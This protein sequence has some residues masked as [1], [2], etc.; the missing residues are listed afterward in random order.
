MV[1]A[2]EKSCAWQ[3]ESGLVAHGPGTSGI[4][5]GADIKKAK[6][7]MVEVSRAMDTDPEYG[8]LVLETPEVWGV[9]DLGA[10]SVVIRMVVK[11]KPGAQWTASRVMHERIKAAFDDAGIED[12]VRSTHCLGSRR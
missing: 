4:G 10:D 1:R 6:E 7:I 9:E 8:E 3:Q 5:Y 2:T 12:P 11:T